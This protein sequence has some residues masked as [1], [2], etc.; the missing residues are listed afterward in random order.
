MSI[1]PFFS[2]FIFL[3]I[4]FFYLIRSLPILIFSD[5]WSRSTTPRTQRHLRAADRPRASSSLGALQAPPCSRPASSARRPTGRSARPHPEGPSY[6]RPCSDSSA[7]P[8]LG[9]PASSSSTRS[10]SSAR[11]RPGVPV[12]HALR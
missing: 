11:P 6:V 5:S 9:L 8:C 7:R 4:F 10:D 3:F 12:L 1:I 2:F